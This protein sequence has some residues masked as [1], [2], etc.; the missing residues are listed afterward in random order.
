MVPTY[1]T[2]GEAIAFGGRALGDGEPKYLNTTTT[3]VYT[4]GRHLYALNFARARP[5][6]AI[7]R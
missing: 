5:R 1:S 7:G 2:T 3:P 4:K 6:N